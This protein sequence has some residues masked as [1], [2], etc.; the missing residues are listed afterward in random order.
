M[1]KNVNG[2]LNN[3]K[4]KAIT[5]NNNEGFKDTVRSKRRANH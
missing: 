1:K 2:E 4:F 3:S 5:Y